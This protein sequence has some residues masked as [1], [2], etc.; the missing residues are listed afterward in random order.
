MSDADGPLTHSLDRR[1]E[2]DAARRW[3]SAV[4]SARRDFEKTIVPHLQ[5]AYALARRLTRDPHDAEDAV[6]EACLRALRYFGSF[7]GT[8]AR[9]W[10]LTIVRNWC[11]TLQRRRRADTLTPFDELIHSDEASSD[12]SDVA[13]GRAFLRASLED[14][15]RRL[16]REYRDVIILR[17]LRELSYREIGELVGAPIGTVMSRLFRARQRLRQELAST[18]A[19]S[20]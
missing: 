17:E 4:S 19:D 3:T 8:D 15:L 13:A 7:Q 2:R 6:Q 16:P 1:A 12:P 14:A 10:L 18:L 9:A 5:A 20:A 11:I